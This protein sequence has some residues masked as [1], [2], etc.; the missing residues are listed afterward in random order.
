MLGRRTY[1]QDELDHA[2]R[3]IEAQLGAYRRLADAVRGDSEAEAAL[4]EFEPLF[5]A[6]LTLVLDRYFV[7]RI[8]AVSGKDG[9]PLNE[10][11]LLTESV[12]SN[13]GE[14]R[15]N[16]VIK[17]KPDETVLKLA[18]G[19]PIRIDADGF[20]RLAAAFLGEIRTRFV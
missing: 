14:F 16:N 11:E 15:G 17:L 3:A 6:N 18:P 9:N 5:F 19:D 2:T 4:A 10:V 12:M 20:E 1:T 7:H 13:G 8:R